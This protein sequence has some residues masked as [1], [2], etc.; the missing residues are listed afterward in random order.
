[1]KILVL[2]SVS[3]SQK[4]C[5]YEMGDTLPE[6]PPN[7]PWEAKVEWEAGSAQVRMMDS[8]GGAFRD[9]VKSDSR[10][11]ALDHLFRSL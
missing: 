3:S 4:S 11:Q 6:H 9:R 7:L 8:E 10:P 2:N 5:L 1:M